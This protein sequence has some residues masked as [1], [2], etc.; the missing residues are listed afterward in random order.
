MLTFS[1]SA[2]SA[3]PSSPKSFF[4]KLHTTGELGQRV[5]ADSFPNRAGEGGAA[6]LSD[7]SVALTLR[8]S[9]STMMPSA[10]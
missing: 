2:M 1:T 3:L 10:V 7:V 4:S 8:A 9:H 6:H 5:A